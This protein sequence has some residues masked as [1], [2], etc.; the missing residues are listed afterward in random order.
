MACSSGSAA[1]HQGAAY[2]GPV[3]DLDRHGPRA[4]VEC[5]Q[6]ARPG[7]PR[8]RRQLADLDQALP[9]AAGLGAPGH[10]A[11]HRAP[12]RPPGAGRQVAGRGAQR[13]FPSR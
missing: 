9:A 13:P 4:D 7:L 2:R 12:A 8:L 6:P 10:R 1:G 11:E 3:G 5:R